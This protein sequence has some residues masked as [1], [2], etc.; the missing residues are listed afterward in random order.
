MRRNSEVYVCKRRGRETEK[1]TY[2]VSERHRWTET[3][4]QKEH[5][6]ID[7]HYHEQRYRDG[8]RE[9]DR[10]RERERERER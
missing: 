7:F 1:E 6:Y 8:E 5:K 2:K 4:R 9:R 3:V 10:E